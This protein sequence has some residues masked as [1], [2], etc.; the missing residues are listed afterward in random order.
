[1]SYK[2]HT[3]ENELNQLLKVSFLDLDFENT[4]H[5]KMIDMIA[6]TY[7]TKTPFINWKVYLKKY[8]IPFGISLIVLASLGIFLYSNLLSN[9]NQ[10]P[11]YQPVKISSI[12]G[13]D[14]DSSDFNFSNE[15]KIHLSMNSL[16]TIETPTLSR[17]T[18]KQ[19]K[20]NNFHLSNYQANDYTINNDSVVL[21]SLTE[22][23]MK[24]ARKKKAEMLKDLY[25][26]NKRE[27]SLIPEGE[28]EIEGKKHKI[29]SFYMQSKEVTNEQYR[30]FFFDII[31]NRKI[32]EF[33]IA[34][35][36]VKKWNKVGKP[37]SP[38][39]QF[40]F[41]HPAY[42]TYPVVNISRKAAELYCVWLSEEY[43]KAYG[44]ARKSRVIDFRI[45]S[46]VEWMYAASSGG[47]YY[48]YPWG[49]PNVR[50][51]E[52]QFLANY[53]AFKNSKNGLKLISPASTNTFFPNEFG[54][55]N[56]SGNVA[57]MVYNIKTKKAGTKGGSW[58]SIAEQIK[59]LG[60]DPFEGKTD[61]DPEIGFRVVFTY[62]NQ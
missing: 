13:F 41:N 23:E 52:G 5:Q 62:L 48:P 14:K 35:P 54:L 30:A 37:N 39:V 29:Y 21:P 58:N 59:I 42:N 33:I 3:T 18:A 61:A 16:A 19:P 55:Y 12:G 20:T 32:K 7:S 49:G 34:E 10:N 8:K 46:D 36:D 1:M 51:N 24:F 50:N 53:K 25:K 9:N 11:S 45:P 26:L 27:Y 44:E 6:T 15:S 28:I 40:Y 57:E 22:E 47:K 56:M 60:E 38:F 17:R 31:M 2:S 43:E 4:N